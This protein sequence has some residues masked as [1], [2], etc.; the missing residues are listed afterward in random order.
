MMISVVIITKNEENNIIDCIA[1]ARLITNDI[2]VVDSES[3]DQTVALAVQE[4]ATV[5]AMDWNGY[6]TAKNSGANRA[7]HNW[8]FSLDADERITPQLAC[9][10]KKLKLNDADCVY[11]FTRTNYIGNKKIKFGTGGFDKVTRLY[12]KQNVNWDLTAVHEKLVGANTKEKIKGRLIHYSAK[13][14]QD[15]KEK[16]IFYAKLSAE[17]YFEQS[18]HAGFTKRFVAP[19]FNSFKSYFLQFGFLDGRTGFGLARLIS[20]YTWLKYHQLHQL[21]QKKTE[22]KR[23]SLRWQKS[24]SNTAI[25][26]SR[27]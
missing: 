4:G 16:I 11:Q 26:F 10:I 13:S 25:S 17:K 27:K 15:Y 20:Y 23:V 21:E 12:N 5:F 9:S 22:N 2:I 1:S 6:G 8:I 18:L 3:A 24:T 7:K 14:L 19:L